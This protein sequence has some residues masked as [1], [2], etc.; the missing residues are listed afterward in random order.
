MVKYYK[1][2]ITLVPP[3]N[4]KFLDCFAIEDI[5][6]ILTRAA[7]SMGPDAR[8]YI[9]ET[10]W[11]RQKYEAAAYSLNYASL[12]FTAM[13]NGKSRMYHSEE[14][15]EAIQKAGLKVIDDTDNLGVSHTLLTCGR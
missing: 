6:Q 13:A 11:D 5:V 3:L 9:L 2:E 15:I 4:T 1:R 10:F 8:L 12:Y 14:M 7:K